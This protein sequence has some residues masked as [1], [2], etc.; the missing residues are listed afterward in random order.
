MNDRDVVD[1][2]R[3]KVG[4]DFETVFRG[5]DCI[6]VSFHDEKSLFRGLIRHHSSVMTQ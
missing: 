3:R 5:D 4:S 2:L 6:S 1:L